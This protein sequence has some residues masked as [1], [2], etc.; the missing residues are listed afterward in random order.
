MKWRRF[1]VGMGCVLLLQ[2]CSAHRAFY[3][4]NRNL[5]A[6]PDHSG[7]KC[8]LVEFPSLNGKKL[9]GLYFS[10]AQA[11][12]GTIVH[13]HGNYGN[14]SNHFPLST[15][16]VRKGFDVLIFDYEGYGASE[17]KP[18]PKNLVNDGIAA[19]RYAQAHLRDPNTGVGLFGQSLG[20]AV[21]IVVA[22]KTP[23]VKAVVIEAA[24]SSYPTMGAT[25]LRRSAITWAFSPL[26]YV[27][28]GRTY[29]P[30]RYV[31]N[32]S[33]RP[34]FFIHGEADEIVPVK[35]SDELYAAAK[36]PKTLWKVPGARHLTVGRQV[37]ADYETRITT[38]FSEALTQR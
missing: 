2:G 23:E 19:V 5:Y 29:N 35:M 31:K 11:P 16:L 32:I 36:E 25:A 12:R 10:T 8:E 34:V 1:F 18:T 24:F 21:G 26:A 4:P 3:Y 33:P 13:F 27:F 9:Y 17:G 7:L 38:F 20:G 22:S 15:F 6:N 14:V 30:V 28:L 37:A